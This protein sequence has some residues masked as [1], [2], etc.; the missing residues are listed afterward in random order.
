MNK[1]GQ[2]SIIAALLVAVILIAT[3]I[4]TYSTIRNF[5]TGEQPQVL[6]AIDE[7]N[8][9]LKQI[10]GFTVGYYGSV[11][12]VTG[13]RDYAHDSAYKYLVSGLEYI[14]RMHPERAVSFNLSEL[15]LQTYWFTS[16]SYSQG[17][18]AVKYDLT[19]LGIYGITYETSCKLSVNVTGAGNNQARVRVTVDEKNEPLIN[20]G[21]SS[22]KFYRYR[23][24]NSTWELVSPANEPTAFADGTYLI[25]IP[26][27]I[28]Q[29][30]YV[31]Q[32]EDQRGI[33]AVAS[34]FSRYICTLNWNP[35]ITLINRESFEG[36]W[37][38]TDWNVTNWVRTNE[39]KYEG[40]YS[41]MFT[42]SGGTSSGDLT[43]R[44]LDCS[45]AVSIYIEFWYNNS[46]SQNAKFSLQCFNGNIWVKIADLG[47]TS[48]WSNY[49]LRITDS[50]FFKSNFKI[51]W[52]ALSV[53]EK[54]KVYVDYVTVKKGISLPA[55]NEPIVV[56]L[57]QN[58]T[59]RWPGQN[60]NL[61]TQVKPIPPIPVK[62]IHVNQTINGVD[63]EVP[64]QIEDW[65]SD[66]RI[67]L[68]LTNN[69]SVFNN[70]NML[71]F[72]A[73]RNVSKVT[74]WWNGS[75]TATQTPLAYTN[76]YFTSSSTS[77]TRTVRTNILELTLNW[78]DGSLR[79]ISR[80]GSVTA[81]AVL[82]R[83]NDKVARW[84]SSA[85][86]VAIQNG[87]VRAILHHEVEW[88]SST[89]YQIPECPNFYAHI[90]LTLPA[91]ATYYTYQLR[92]MFLESNKPRTIRDL[93]PIKVTSSSGTFSLTEN[94]VAN[95]YPIISNASRLFYNASNVW[96]HHWAQI[97]STL[98]KGFGIMFTDTANKLLYHFDNKAEYNTLGKQT[99]ALNVTA[100]IRTIELL[101]VAKSLNAPVSF[102]NTLDITWYGAI[103]T[104]DGT[105][106]IY[107]KEG[108]NVTGLWILA[109]YPPSIT[110]TTES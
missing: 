108:S 55:P 22:F 60:L 23:Y 26:S 54:D 93:C 36:S 24:S 85:P 95:G 80:M 83:I 5:P 87:V 104:F 17:R 38:P 15:D 89:S 82:M 73:N 72:L 97:N 77:N 91:N 103:V 92:L 42:K 107:K 99:G 96:Q 30:S 63:R 68:G 62:A 8:L 66:Y 33:V 76:K 31:V 4:I 109:E 44:G 49:Q 39:Q 86:A 43:S 28:D 58:G 102:T 14:A 57:L 106:P 40:M 61:A 110:V 3:V 45:D 41:A 51:R 20:L 37:P 2:F 74:I 84:G 18:I 56:E 71:V 53:G 59:M 32:V 100:N 70:R 52:S 12:Q 46:I 69:A 64:F 25:D 81:T 47:S 65:A 6:S 88:G 50:Q 27:G 48:S 34:S 29:Y 21:K 78:S 98:T 16:Q 90:V 7:T 10:L 75:D 94:G 13:D 1:K 19:G 9:A 101:P 67:P 105:T 35:N 79:A 11:L